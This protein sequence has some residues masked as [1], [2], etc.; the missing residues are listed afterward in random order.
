[1]TKLRYTNIS[2]VDAGTKSLTKVASSG[3]YTITAA[4][5]ADCNHLAF[6]VDGTSASGDYN[7]TMPAV[8]DWS[9]KTISFLIKVAMASGDVTIK[10]SDGSTYNTATDGDLVGN[11]IVVHCDGVNVHEL[12][13]TGWD[14]YAGL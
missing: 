3:D 9:G 14:A 8:A 6:Y 12:I 7:V 13:E 4:D 11:V 10:T 5:M 2:W 1:M